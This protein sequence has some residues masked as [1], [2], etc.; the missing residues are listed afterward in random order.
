[1]PIFVA[2]RIMR[3]QILHR[4]DAEPTQRENLGRGIHSSSARR[5]RDFHQFGRSLCSARLPLVAALP[6]AFQASLAFVFI[7]SN[8]K[9]D[10]P[11]R[12]RQSYSCA[13]ENK[14]RATMVIALAQDGRSRCFSFTTRG[15]AT[16]STSRAKK[17]G[18]GFPLPN[19][20][21]I[22]CQWRKSKFSS[23]N[24]SS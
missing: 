18:C 3:E 15:G 7:R 2:S 17:S 20:C 24:V 1:M 21:S 8:P 19:G 22:S 16:G 23:E 6:P 12:R 9:R 4:L 13:V 5:L 14:S 11:W 10:V